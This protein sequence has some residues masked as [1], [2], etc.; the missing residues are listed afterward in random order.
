[1]SGGTGARQQL[2]KAPYGESE[3]CRRRPIRWNTALASE[4]MARAGAADRFPHLRKHSAKRQ[5]RSDI[6]AA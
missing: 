5:Y 3:L 4:V 6:G 2:D 1:M